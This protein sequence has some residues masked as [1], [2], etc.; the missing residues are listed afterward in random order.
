MTKDYKVSWGEIEETCEAI[1]VKLDK[2]GVWPTRIVAVANGGLVP[3][4]ILA[5]LCGVREID[6]IQ[7]SHYDPECHAI[8][9]QHVTI[10]DVNLGLPGDGDVIMVVDDIFDTG[11]TL[12]AVMGNIN[13]RLR[14]KEVRTISATLFIRE[15]CAGRPDHHGKVVS[16]GQWLEFPWEK[17]KWRDGKP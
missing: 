1:M 17:G 12:R 9:K 4:S 13:T 5:N 16:K 14:S 7:A 8:P 11:D 6:Y 2:S 10:G 3:A 15:G